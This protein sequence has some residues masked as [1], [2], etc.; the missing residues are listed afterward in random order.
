MKDLLLIIDMQNAY[1]PDAPWECPS[2]LSALEHIIQLL[3]HPAC[4]TAYD[5]V[6][7]R[8]IASEKPAGRWVQYNDANRVINENPFLNQIIPALQP[9]LMRWPFH[10]KSAYSACSN[11]RVADMIPRYDHILISGVVAECC[12]LC[13][14]AGLIDA[15]AHVIYLSDAVSGRSREL[16][17]MSRAF[18][19]GFS[20]IHAQILNTADYL[21]LL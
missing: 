12:V 8:Y 4:G 21:S 15:G 14:A 9:Y 1:M 13:T 6:F 3:E 19:D 10:D 7:T 5:P 16:E 2:I 18:I 17:Q 11:T 20:P